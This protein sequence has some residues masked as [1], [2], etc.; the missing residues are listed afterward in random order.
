M[1]G[2]ME[3]GAAEDRGEVRAGECGGDQAR[4][5]GQGVERHDESPGRP[6]ELFPHLA[7]NKN[8]KVNPGHSAI[9]HLDPVDPGH[10][11]LR[12]GQRSAIQR[13]AHIRP[14]TKTT[15]SPWTSVCHRGNTI[16]NRARVPQG[17]PYA[18]TRWTTTG[19]YTTPRGTVTLFNF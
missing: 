12:R 19:H 3:I 13:A 7:G 4:H 2:L 17:F 9:E 16:R 5:I 8:V 18:R 6:V 11:R 14:L 15:R 1:S 10:E